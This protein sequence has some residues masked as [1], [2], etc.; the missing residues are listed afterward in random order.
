VGIGHFSTSLTLGVPLSSFSAW[1]SLDFSLALGI[2]FSI[3]SPIYL[4][5]SQNGNNLALFMIILGNYLQTLIVRI[6]LSLGR[7]FPFL[8]STQ[9]IGKF[10]QMVFG[11]SNLFIHPSEHSLK[12]LILFTLLLHES[13]KNIFQGRSRL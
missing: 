2:P 7:E 12:C 10:G 13:T 4:T 3:F 6:G 8:G 5:T 11:L 9:S 1:V